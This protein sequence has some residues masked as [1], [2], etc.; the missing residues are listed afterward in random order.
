MYDPK[1]NKFLGGKHMSLGQFAIDKFNR[2]YNL[3]ELV[4]EAGYPTKEYMDA[5]KEMKRNYKGRMH[6]TLI[7]VNP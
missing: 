3:E 7:V 1:K 6:F 5:I 2:E 4:D